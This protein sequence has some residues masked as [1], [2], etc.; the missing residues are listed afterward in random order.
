[1]K[2]LFVL[3]HAK[4]DWDA[5]SGGDH[6]RPLNDR[7]EASAETIGRFL[8]GLGQMPERI[9]TS[10][11]VRARTTV[12]IAS[13]AGAW[14]SAIVPSGELYEASSATLLELVRRQDDTIS[15][16]LL[17]GHEPTVSD[18]VGR[19]AGDAKVR[20][21]T[22]ALARLDVAVNRWD[23]VCF[24]QAALAWLVTPKLLAAAAKI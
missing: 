18:F 24:G 13:R 1:M 6:E 19:M 21:V 15:S 5:G 2:R 12:E 22:A 14:P 3:R 11:A 7:G 10:T 20:M 9:L 17:A 8:A 4:S 16:L 23:E